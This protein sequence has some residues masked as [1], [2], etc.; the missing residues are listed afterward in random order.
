MNEKGQIIEALQ[1]R[2][3]ATE[4]EDLMDILLG[5]D[6]RSEILEGDSTVS[7]ARQGEWMPFRDSFA[8]LL[9]EGIVDGRWFEEPVITDEEVPGVWRCWLVTTKS[10]A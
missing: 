1:G 9:N 10:S 8:E 4:L 7:E 5:P 3:G 2:K 6:A